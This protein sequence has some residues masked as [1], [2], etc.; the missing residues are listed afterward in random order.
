MRAIEDEMSDD[1]E[2]AL[3][4]VICLTSSEAFLSY[5]LGVQAPHVRSRPKQD[6]VRLSSR[7]DYQQTEALRARGSSPRTTARSYSLAPPRA[8]G[9]AP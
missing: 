3:Y 9:G 2:V 5:M 8:R 1:F 6:S 4:D 7:L